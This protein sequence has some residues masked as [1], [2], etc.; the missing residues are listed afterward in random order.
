M[1]VSFYLL[2]KIKRAFYI[3]SNAM[4]EAD[5]HETE[6]KKVFCFSTHRPWSVPLLASAE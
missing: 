6:I 5:M 1:C 4:V 3:L 2:S